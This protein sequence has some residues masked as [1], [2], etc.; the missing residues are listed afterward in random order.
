MSL[1]ASNTVATELAATTAAW[2]LRSG[3]AS[4]KRDLETRRSSSDGIL[5]DV[6]EEEEE[7][8]VVV[9][10]GGEEMVKADLLA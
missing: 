9:V 4:S 7:G 3:K 8:V 2:I 10:E 6:A 5:D 1:M